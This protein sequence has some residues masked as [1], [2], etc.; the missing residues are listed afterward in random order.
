MEIWLT[1]CLWPHIGPHGVRCSQRTRF[2]HPPGSLPFRGVEESAQSEHRPEPLPADS[3]TSNEGHHGLAVQAGDPP[4]GCLLD[5]PAATRVSLMNPCVHDILPHWFRHC[6]PK[7]RARQPSTGR[8][9]A[10]ALPSRNHF[11]SSQNGYGRPASLQ[12]ELAQPQEHHIIT[13][14]Q[15]WHPL[16]R[17]RLGCRGPDPARLVTAGEL[18]AP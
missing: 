7:G 13:G 4:P 15:G 11:R 1:R 14:V 2:H 10:D 3:H 16:L 12:L 17:T 8:P 5:S 6:E 18:R 9:E